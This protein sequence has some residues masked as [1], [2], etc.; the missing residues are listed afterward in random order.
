MMS[1]VP[2]V[3]GHLPRLSLTSASTVT[4]AVR[5]GASAPH[6]GAHGAAKCLG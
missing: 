6:G 2:A 4:S 1:A 3:F 5:H